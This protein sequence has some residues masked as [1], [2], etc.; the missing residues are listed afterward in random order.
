[1]GIMK[2]YKQ[3]GVNIHLK[4]NKKAEVKYENTKSILS[5]SSI[6]PLKR[7]SLFGDEGKSYHERLYGKDTETGAFINDHVLS[8]TVEQL[9]EE[10]SEL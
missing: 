8:K 6:A 2:S 4:E 3:T 1:M 10:H 7:H 9:Y 5:Q